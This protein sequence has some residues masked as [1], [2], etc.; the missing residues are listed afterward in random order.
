M[1]Q[2]LINVLTLRILGWTRAANINVPCN[3]AWVNLDIVACCCYQL[4]RVRYILWMTTIST[5]TTSPRA[6][7]TS[8][9]YLL[10]TC[11]SSSPSLKSPRSRATTTHILTRLTSTSSTR[12]MT[13]RHRPGGR[14]QC[15]SLPSPYSATLTQIVICLYPLLGDPVCL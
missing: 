6:L 10:S 12:S 9:A 13:A 14:R 2:L 4:F 11:A 15:R 7:V 5:A 8:L 3:L 1:L